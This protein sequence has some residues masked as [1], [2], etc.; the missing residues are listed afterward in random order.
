MKSKEKKVQNEKEKEIVVK[1][2]NIK[3]KT[4]I[5]ENSVEKI[6]EKKTQSGFIPSYAKKDEN[7]VKGKKEKKQLPKF[8]IKSKITFTIVISLT[9]LVLA[10][11]ITLVFFIN[12]L[13]YKPYIKYEENMKIYAFD[14]V[15]D[16]KTAKTS[17]KVTKS[18]AIKMVLSA[19]FNTS[20]ISGF[21]KNPEDTYENARWVKYAVDRGIIPQNE[22]TKENYNKKAT[23]IDV[24]RYFA[25]VKSKIL[26]K[27]LDS[28]ETTVKD[29]N[30]YS[31]D[32]QLAINDMLYNKIFE[33]KGKKLKGRNKVFKGQLNEMIKNF[34]EKYNTITIDGAKIN[35]NPDKK[36]S[37]A[38]EYPYTLAN[39]DKSVY[40]I[41]F[42]IIDKSEFKNPKHL[43][44]QRKEFYTQM[45]SKAEGYL[46][47][48]LNIDYNNI[49]LE[50]LKNDLEKY[51]SYPIED[52]YLNEYVE[53]VKANNIKITT[54]V[55]TQLP[56]LYYDGSSYRVRT[57]VELKID[58]SNTKMNLLLGDL[59][60]GEKINY[61]ESSYSIY[62]DL[63][64]ENVG[65]TRT[66]YIDRDCIYTMIP[67]K[68]KVKITNERGE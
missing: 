45:Q 14:S 13:K 43:Y 40:E 51:L 15:Y 10:A 35:I 6:E 22:I 29:I 63:K 39:I 44:A 67:N 66:T 4:T 53:Y 16:N 31:S 25:A 1:Q 11:I 27:A 38:S 46:N 21:S 42:F 8:V 54:K 49:S 59:L 55:S 3:A 18:E 50:K 62:V 64:M 7:K 9:I 20:D 68:E 56:C 32:E 34:V 47:T 61:L 58:N 36:P 41:P 2:K 12:S 65:G 48:I 17:D 52:K 30:G 60:K 26:N 57:K 19:V 5:G 37:N 23:Y 28:S 24:I 33:L